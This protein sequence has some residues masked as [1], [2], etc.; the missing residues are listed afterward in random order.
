MEEYKIAICDDSSTELKIIFNQATAILEKRKIQYSIKT[1]KSGSD[2]ISSDE[3]YD[4]LLLDVEMDNLDGIDIKNVLEHKF[5]HTKIVFIS[6]Y[7]NKV[8]DA[9]GKNV[10]AYIKKENLNNLEH[11]IIKTYREWLNNERIMLNN[12][13]VYIKDIYYLEADNNYTIIH[14]ENKTILVRRIL[15]EFEIDLFKYGFLRVHKSFVINLRFISCVSYASV[16][17]VDEKIIKISRGQNEKI[18]KAH[19]DYIKENSTWE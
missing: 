2:F 13:I 12:Q 16:E 8:L 17:L 3:L 14:L 4:L 9:F 7:Q 1:F 15:K 5:P 19:L 6:N 18:K 10:I 11:V